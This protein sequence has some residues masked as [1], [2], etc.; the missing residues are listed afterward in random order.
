MNSLLSRILV[1]LCR[2]W[3]GFSYNTR[4]FR[5]AR[6][7]A[8]TCNQ[9]YYCSSMKFTRKDLAALYKASRITKQHLTSFLQNTA[10]QQA[11]IILE[12]ERLSRRL[13]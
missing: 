9:I 11:N 4:K 5:A 12:I 13:P 2:P 6:R 8:R 10:L 1:P 3:R 7:H